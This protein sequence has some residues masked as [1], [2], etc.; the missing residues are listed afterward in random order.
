MYLPSFPCLQANPCAIFNGAAA[1][2]KV[3]AL[4][5]STL[6]AVQMLKALSAVSMSASMF[7][8]SPLANPYLILGVLG[9]SLLH[10][11]V[12]RVPAL[13]HLMGLTALDAREWRVVA[14]L[15][16][17]VLLLEELLK[18]VERLRD[19]RKANSAAAHA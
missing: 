18:A 19:A 6:V 12:F 14:A 3:Q 1:K 11:A 9:P 2:G 16:G 4:A 7:T 10:L 8:L 5:L 15:A 13:T 17:P